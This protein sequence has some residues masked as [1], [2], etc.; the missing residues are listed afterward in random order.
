MLHCA[1]LIDD[2]SALHDQLSHCR[3][4]MLYCHVHTQLYYSTVTAICRCSHLSRQLTRRIG[5]LTDC[6]T[7]IHL[8]L[9]HRYLAGL[10][11]AYSGIILYCW[12][13]HVQVASCFYSSSVE[14]DKEVE[15]SGVWWR[16]HVQCMHLSHVI[17]VTHVND[18]TSWCD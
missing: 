1:A 11:Q 16:L 3:H 9:P 10:S 7:S 8:T 15:V 4:Y 18:V 5:A 14:F 12:Y 13:L 2:S 17:L 6:C